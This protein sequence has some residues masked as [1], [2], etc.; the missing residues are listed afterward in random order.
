MTSDLLPEDDKGNLEPVL[1]G[2]EIATAVDTVGFE[3]GHL[4][5]SK[6]RTVGPDDDQNLTFESIGVN[7]EVIA[8]VRAYGEI[9]IRRIAE[10]RPEQDPK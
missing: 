8:T 9:A 2:A 6:T 10:V 7:V 4:G 3:T 1:H 5:D